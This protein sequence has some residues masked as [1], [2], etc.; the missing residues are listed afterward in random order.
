MTYYT[1]HEHV[2]GNQRKSLCHVC[3]AEM[4]A[5]EQA[6][7]HEG[8]VSTKPEDMSGAIV[9]HPECA[10]ILGARLLHD[11]VKQ[12][13]EDNIPQGEARV[14]HALRDIRSTYQYKGN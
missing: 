5:D 1:R 4:S 2:F 11:V 12:P 6:I 7:V 14:L 10:L 3:S 13:S 9:L 8:W